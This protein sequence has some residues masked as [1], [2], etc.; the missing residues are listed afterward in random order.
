MKWAEDEIKRRLFSQLG[1][2]TDGRWDTWNHGWEI[3][4]WKWKKKWTETEMKLCS[5]ARF[6]SLS[7]RP[8]GRVRG[9]SAFWAS[10]T[11]VPLTLPALPD[12]PGFL[13]SYASSMHKEDLN[14]IHV[15]QTMRFPVFPE[16][17]YFFLLYP[18]P[19][20]LYEEGHDLFPLWDTFIRTWYARIFRKNPRNYL[21]NWCSLDMNWSIIHM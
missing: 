13:T 4:V 16:K 19:H 3:P 1:I 20:S 21:N 11:R 18:S 10:K 14:C 12:K 17:T 7:P 8:W 5:S 2:S 9:V 6:H 15:K